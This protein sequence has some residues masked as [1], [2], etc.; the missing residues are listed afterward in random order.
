MKKYNTINL[1]LAITMLII[2]FVSLFFLPSNVPIHTHFG[3][4][5]EWGSKYTNFIAP[6]IAFILW[7][8][9]P[10][11]MSRKKDQAELLGGDLGEKYLVKNRIIINLVFLVFAEFDL[12]WVCNMPFFKAKE[13][14][15]IN[16]L[17]RSNT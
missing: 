9:M 15:R 8:M 10:K 14:L 4:I 5:D 2:T 16:A 17:N 12:Y 1:I 7:F 11:I 3:R 13:G 6:A